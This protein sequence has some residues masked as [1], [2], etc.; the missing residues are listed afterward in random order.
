ME[1]TILTHKTWWERFGCFCPQKHDPGAQLRS[2]Q[3]SVYSLDRWGLL[4]RA[5]AR[6]TVWAI[7]FSSTPHPHFCLLSLFSSSS[8]PVKKDSK[9]DGLISP[10]H[11]PSCAF[12]HALE[13]PDAPSRSVKAACLSLSLS[14]SV[15]QI[16]LSLFLP[17]SFLPVFLS[18]SLCLLQPNE[19]SPMEVVLSPWGPNDQRG[20]FSKQEEP[21]SKR[22]IGWNRILT[23]PSPQSSLS[24][25]SPLHPLQVCSLGLIYSSLHG[26]IGAGETLL[27]P[28]TVCV[29]L[30]LGGL[31]AHIS[32]HVSPMLPRVSRGSRIHYHLSFG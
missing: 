32:I 6:G 22:R 16:S 25:Q 21:V 2:K 20:N 24:P 7:I 18:L 12:F 30:Q 28:E 23:P 17:L 15:S 5:E 9:N 3:T 27:R 14:L 19:S 10:H 29:L 1:N 13:S 11:K 4:S 26:E 31:F 8:F